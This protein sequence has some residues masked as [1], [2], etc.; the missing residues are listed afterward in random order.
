MSQH[1]SAIVLNGCVFLFMLGVGMMVALLPL[2]IVTLSGSVSYAGY[3]AAAF[4]VPYVLLQLPI[5]AL[6]DA[7]GFKGFLSAGYLL[8]ALT[9]ILYYAAGT[10]IWLLFGR[11]LQGVGEAPLWALPPALLSLLYP[12]SKGKMMGAYNASIHVGLTAGS[13][14]G[15]VMLRSW[16]G[17]QAFLLFAAVSLAG[18]LL[19]LFLLDNPPQRVLGQTLRVDYRQLL[20]LTRTRGNATVLLGIALYGAG[21]GTFLTIIP[22][23]LSEAKHAQ[24]GFVGVVFALFY[25]AISLS[26]LVA[27]PL[28]DRWP[29]KGLMAA[30]MLMA[31]VGLT[32]FV[33]L[34][35]PWLT[36]ALILASFGLGVFAVS[37][38][39]FLN[40]LVPDALKGTI[41]GAFYVFWGLGYF[42]VPLILGR[43]SQAGSFGL[44]F[45]A[46]AGLFLL[47]AMALAVGCKA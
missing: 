21:Y 37:A 30:G 42:F 34:Q 46:L 20:A 29:R 27:G 39:A 26:Q 15:V 11:L 9:G 31:S 44:G 41:S 45:G 17:N 24:P 35:P 2:R 13:L 32:G 25:I 36:V 22:A 10:P 7:F 47:G 14:L 18:G 38:M 40:D 28:T 12:A 19:T 1:R 23:T 33:P 16:Q 8:C 5:G 6:A 43:L 3:L 4:A